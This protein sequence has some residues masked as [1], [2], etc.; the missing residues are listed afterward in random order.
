MMKDD[1]IVHDDDDELTI[2]GRLR[3]VMIPMLCF[4]AGLVLLLVGIAATALCIAKGQGLSLAA[5][6]GVILVIAGVVVTAMT[7]RKWPTL[8][9]NDP[10]TPRTRRYGWSM[11]ALIGFAVVTSLFFI[12]LGNGRMATELFSNGPLPTPAAL[13]AAA[14]WLVGLPLVAALTRRNMDEVER[15]LLVT[16]ESTGFRF[17]SIAA[18]VW[19]LGYRG[20]VLPQ[21]DVMILFVAVLM[22]SSAGNLARRI[23]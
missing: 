14:L 6:L 1:R 8:N 16:G 18:P 11:I 23:A 4:V 7:F 22:V 5:A 21:P 3:G 12:R 13:I 10:I 17:F 15:G 19:W 2:A 20:G 9:Q